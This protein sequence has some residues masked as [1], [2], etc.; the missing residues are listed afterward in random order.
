MIIREILVE[1]QAIAWLPWAVSYFFFIG[2][3]FSCVWVGILLKSFKQSRQAEFIAVSLA[4]IFALV[5]PIALTADLHQP[6]RISHFYLNFTP[7]SWMAWGAIFLPLFTLSVMGYFICLLRQAIPKSHLNKVCHI[8]YWGRLNVPLWTTFFRMSSA[9]TALLI[10][11]YTTME[12]FMVAAR[13]LWHHYWLMPLILFSI[14]PVAL[15]LCQFCIHFWLKQK[16]PVIFTY[17][18]LASLLG[19]MISIVGLYLSS[20]QVASQLA[21]LHSFS[22]V[23]TLC[24][25]CF[26]LMVGAVFV[27]KTWLT[28]LGGIFAL[29]FAWTVRWILLIE[30]QRIAKYNALINPYSLRWEI[31]GAIGILSVFGLCILL[32]FIFWQFFY[33]TLQATNL[34]GGNNE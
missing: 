23:S 34:T 33:R 3:A 29:F 17:F 7:W 32:T 21:Q 31:D 25:C 18:T 20:T 10:L 14:L 24:L 13:P 22:F 8:L 11:I 15:L 30:V 16:L 28:F 5:A 1:P 6:S 12:V 19:F 4:M 27:S 26:I 9:I 2:L